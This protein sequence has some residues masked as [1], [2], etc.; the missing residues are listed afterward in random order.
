[1]KIRNIFDTFYF[2]YHK[3]GKNDAQAK[4]KIS[5]VYKKDAL[6]RQTSQTAAN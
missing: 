4:E 3:K 6:T 2:F 5:R 1:V